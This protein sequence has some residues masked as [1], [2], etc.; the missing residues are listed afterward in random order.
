MTPVD[1]ALDIIRRGTDEILLEE[2]LRA[3]LARV[4]T[5]RDMLG[6]ATAHFA[7]ERG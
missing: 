5:E 4:N 2:P 1:E 3:K 6:N 7:K